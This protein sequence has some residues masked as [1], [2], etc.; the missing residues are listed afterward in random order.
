MNL[1]VLEPLPPLPSHT[2]ST[3]VGLWVDATEM[4]VGAVFLSDWGGGTNRPQGRSLLEPPAW[5][6]PLTFAPQR[7]T[8]VY[9]SDQQPAHR[10]A[11]SSLLTAPFSQIASGAR[12]PGVDR[13]RWPLRR[14]LHGVAQNRQVRRGANSRARTWPMPCRRT[15]LPR[16]C[17]EWLRRKVF[18][19]LLLLDFMNCKRLANFSL[20]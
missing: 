7:I 19:W 10:G 15:L 3:Q 12:V 5:A 14:D 16:Q 1:V 2:P 8:A 9:L 4:A 11:I 13:S 18:S 20:L 6:T 17:R